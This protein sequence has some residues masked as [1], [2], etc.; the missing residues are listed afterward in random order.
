MSLGVFL[1]F[2]I[3]DDGDG[4][5]TGDVQAG[6]EH[7]EDTVDA[8]DEGEALHR[9]VDAL[10]DHRE[11]DEASARDTCCADGGQRT[12]Q[13]DHGHLAVR[14]V[15]AKDIRDEQRADAHVEGRA[16]HVDR[17]TERQ[18]EGGD[19]ARY[20][21]LLL[22]VLH[23]D[24]QRCCTRAGRKSNQ[25]RLTHAAEELCRRVAA[26]DLGERRV[27]RDRVDDAADG[28]AGDD[29]DQRQQYGRAVLGD[30][31]QQQ[32]EDADRS[33]AHDDADDLVGDL[34]AG[35]E[36]LDQ[37]IRAL[38][39]DLEDAD[40]DEECEDD[41]RQDVGLSHRGDR[42]GRDHRDE[43]LHDRRCFLALDD[44]VRRHLQADARMRKT[45]DTKADDNRDG[46]RD[47]VEQ[48][49]LDADA[50]ELR[51]VAEAC[52]ADD[53]RA[54]DDRDD[55]H[56]DEVD[57]DRAD[58]CDPPVDERQGRFTRDETDDDGQHERNKNLDG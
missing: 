34:C 26:P 19:I 7:V 45:R 42:V 32:G 40:A 54:E 27:D 31:R 55:H 56:L 10:Q 48:D 8:G 38:A 52:H 50:A 9:E 30:D 41:D 14:Q 39:A 28:D 18:D 21:E 17:R 36:E 15:N 29:G 44:S 6:A 35:V 3:H 24:W 4:A 12:G 23:V 25:H 5:V 47:E 11:H 57:E 37:D 46:R 1:F 49:G 53:E 51:R 2:L 16:I 58:R 43:D 13:D 20:T 33:E 22:A